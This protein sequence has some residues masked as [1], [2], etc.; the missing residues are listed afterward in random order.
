W[1]PRHAGG[2]GKVLHVRPIYETVEMSVPE[3]YCSD[4]D[5]S[6]ASTDPGRA[7]LAGA[8]VGGVLGGV[9]GNQIGKG[10][11]RKVMTIAGT[12]LGVAIGYQAGPR[13]AGLS[14]ATEWSQ[15]HCETRDRT[16]IREALVGYRV[17]YRYRGRIYH[18]RTDDHP[19][20][21]IRVDHRMRPVH[22]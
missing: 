8:V 2:Y 13:V 12:A 22:F 15:S 6:E 21:R 4:G 3:E 20:D 1:G 18:V 16:E 19:G 11:G 17:K 10:T 14:D 5:L 7:A 9:V